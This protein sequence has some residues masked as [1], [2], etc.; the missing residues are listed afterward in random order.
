GAGGLRRV[1][2]QGQ[3]RDPGGQLRRGRRAHPLWTSERLLRASGVLALGTTAR[4]AD[5]SGDRGRLRVGGRPAARVR[6]AGPR[7]ADR[8]RAAPGQRRAGRVRVDLPPAAPGVVAGLAG[9]VPHVRIPLMSA[10]VAPKGTAPTAPKGTVLEA[11]L[12]RI[13]YANEE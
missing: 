1:A 6:F 4:P 10:P 3:R 9:A 8:Q 12:E 7:P 13:T 2:G 5:R 11:V